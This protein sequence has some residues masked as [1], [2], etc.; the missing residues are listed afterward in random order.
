MV[1]FL[2]VLMPM[3]S[4]ATA[5]VGLT[6][7]AFERVSLRVLGMQAAWQFSEPD[8][9]QADLQK[10]VAAGL[11]SEIGMSRF[12]LDSDRIGNRSSVSLL[13]DQ[14]SLP[15]G[16]GLVVPELRVNSHASIAG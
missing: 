7:Y 1:E 14:M 6:W 4:I 16:L 10:F 9:D 13:L 11:K 15:G 3:L 12:S 5:T 2:L 8:F